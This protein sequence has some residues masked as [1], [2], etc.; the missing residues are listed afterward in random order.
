MPCIDPSI[1]VCVWMSSHTSAC[2]HKSKST[3]TA[4]SI[5]R[6]AWLVHTKLLLPLALLEEDPSSPL[7]TAQGSTARPILATLCP[8]D[9]DSRCKRGRWRRQASSMRSARRFQRGARRSQARACVACRVYRYGERHDSVDIQH[10]SCAA[11]QSVGSTHA[12]IPLPFHHPCKP[13][14][15]SSPPAP[16]TSSTCATASSRRASVTYSPPACFREDDAVV[17]REPR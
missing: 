10:A 1:R 15:S 4:R 2:I 16:T 17:E 8:S 14:T 13:P 12:C 11:P 5:T 9:R 3:L 7:P 6:N